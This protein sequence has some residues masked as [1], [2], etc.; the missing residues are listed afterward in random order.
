[1][2]LP[3]ALSAPALL[4]RPIAAAKSGIAALEA[5]RQR[6]RLALTGALL[7]LI[8][9]MDLLVVLPIRDKRIAIESA[10][11]ASVNDEEA[12]RSN[13]QTEQSAHEAD[14]LLRQAQVTKALAAFGASGKRDESLRF[15]LSRTLQGL[16][17]AVLSLR[18]LNVE[19]MEIAPGSAPATADTAMAV[20]AVAAA[21]AAHADPA[22]AAATPDAPAPP[23]QTLLYRHRYEL[24]VGG[25]LPA[26]LSALEALEHNTRPLRIERVHL[27]ADATGAIEASVVLMTLGPE[28]TWLSL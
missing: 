24:R 7:S 1:M 17:V 13:R 26:L 16:P 23:A 14:L 27:Q 2:K 9:G 19:E 5:M 21:P 20:A 22:G 10:Q 25:G 4:A 12:A 3:S 28:R 15:L 11:L 8:I 18:A 6:D